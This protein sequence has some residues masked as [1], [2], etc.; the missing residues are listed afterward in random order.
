ML[1]PFNVS[2][3]PIR[4]EKRALLSE[5]WLWAELPHPLGAYRL[6]S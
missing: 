2:S 6:L 5:G 3:P 1:L 4:E